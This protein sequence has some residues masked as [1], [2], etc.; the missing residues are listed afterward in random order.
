MG[1]VISKSTKKLS[2]KGHVINDPQ[3]IIETDLAAFNVFIRSLH[4]YEKI[5]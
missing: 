2:I 3:D 1:N 5:T 4:E